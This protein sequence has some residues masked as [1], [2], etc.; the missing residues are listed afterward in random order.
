ME[1]APAPHISIAGVITMADRASLAA[2]GP[3]PAHQNLLKVLM[4]LAKSVT[5]ADIET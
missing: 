5:I 2:Y 3:H 4:P 1:P